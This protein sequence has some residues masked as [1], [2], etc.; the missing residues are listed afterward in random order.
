MMSM[1]EV[2]AVRPDGVSA[3]VVPLKVSRFPLTSSPS[4][5]FPSADLFH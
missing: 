4:M 5:R 2:G 1:T 3:T